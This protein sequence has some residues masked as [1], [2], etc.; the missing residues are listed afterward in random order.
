MLDAQPLE[1]PRAAHF[2]LSDRE[3]R[4]AMTTPTQ[5]LAVDV[6]VDDLIRGWQADNEAEDDSAARLLLS[7]RLQSLGPTLRAAR[8]GNLAARCLSAAADGDQQMSA[9][10]SLEIDVAEQANQHGRNGLFII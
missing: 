2:P 5:T 1:K 9:A 8:F 10:L 4:F 6:D 7:H 3:M